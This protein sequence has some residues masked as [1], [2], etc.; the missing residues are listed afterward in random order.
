MNFNQNL[1]GVFLNPNNNKSL[2]YAAT[3]AGRDAVSNMLI[4]VDGTLLTPVHA[5]SF[6]NLP[7]D[8]LDQE[9]LELM[10]QEEMEENTNV[11]V[12]TGYIDNNNNLNLKNQINSNSSNNPKN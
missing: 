6:H 10:L 4:P 1:S 12:A 3:A 5:F 2:S 9:M 11:F 7:G 8:S